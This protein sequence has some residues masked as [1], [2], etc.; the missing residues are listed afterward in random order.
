MWTRGSR[1]GRTERGGTWDSDRSRVD[2]K[3]E[4]L[5]RTLYI[6]VCTVYLHIRQKFLIIYGYL[7]SLQIGTV[8]YKSIVQISDFFSQG[9]TDKVIYRGLGADPQ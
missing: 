6:W 5:K 9:H 7:C 8:I 2:G 1:T 3:Y 4:V